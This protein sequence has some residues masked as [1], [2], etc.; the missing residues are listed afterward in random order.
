MAS[1]EIPSKGTIKRTI[2]LEFTTLA[3][4]K[5]MP[6]TSS[7]YKSRR[8]APRRRKQRSGKKTVQRNRKLIKWRCR[9]HIYLIYTTRKP[10]PPSI[11]LRAMKTRLAAC[12]A[13]LRGL[14]SLGNMGQVLYF[15]SSLRSLTSYVV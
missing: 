8:S 13:R 15:S 3:F 6:S 7:V 2:H 4:I 11:T 5:T 12:A 14:A 10:S 1:S 9:N